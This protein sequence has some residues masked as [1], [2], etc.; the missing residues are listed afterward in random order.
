MTIAKSGMEKLFLGKEDDDLR[1]L[2]RISNPPVDRN[3]LKSPGIS[4]SSSKNCWAKVISEIPNHSG[5]TLEEIEEAT[6]V[7]V[8]EVRAARANTA[9]ED[10]NNATSISA[11]VEKVNIATKALRMST[12]AFNE[13]S[14]AVT[15]AAEEVQNATTS[16]TTSTK[17]VVKLTAPSKKTKEESSN[18]MNKTWDSPKCALNSPTKRA[19]SHDDRE[20]DKD[21]APLNEKEMA[22]REVCTVTDE[23]EAHNTITNTAT[24]T[25]PFKEVKKESD[26]AAISSRI[27]NTWVSPRGGIGALS[28]SP[29]SLNTIHNLNCDIRTVRATFKAIEKD[30][31]AIYEEEK[32]IIPSN[33]EP[34]HKLSNK[35]VCAD[36]RVTIFSDDVLKA[37]TSKAVTKE[38]S[39]EIRKTWVS[40]RD[41]VNSNVRNCI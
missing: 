13:V 14:N 25:A 24:S 11:W 15:S 1:E 17:E 16:T 4:T 22:L 26:P 33:S 21:A 41:G 20:D 19:M 9:L 28:A 23:D 30:P 6:K 39:L 40:P 27:S 10:L 7:K 18:E 2:I 38:S 36:S 34:I 29:K 5:L 35:Y 32:A 37:T 12:A 3:N 8:A 31:T